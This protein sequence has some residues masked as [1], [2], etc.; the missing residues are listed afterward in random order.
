M[1]TRPSRRNTIPRRHCGCR[2]PSRCLRQPDTPRRIHSRRRPLR[3]RRDR[4]A[5]TARRNPRTTPAKRGNRAV[6]MVTSS[7]LGRSPSHTKTSSARPPTRRAARI[8]VERRLPPDLPVQ[9]VERGDASR[10][11][12]RTSALRPSRPRPGRRPSRGNRR[13]AASTMASEGSTPTSEPVVSRVGDHRGHPAIAAA[14]VQHPLIAPD[15]QVAEGVLG[16]GLLKAVD[17][18][19]RLRIPRQP[20]T[21]HVACRLGAGSRQRVHPRAAGRICWTTVRRKPSLAP[22]ALAQW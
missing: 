19:V 22:A 10:T 3:T 8:R 9:G 20:P 1:S 14:D 11:P 13:R 12:T 6:S 15:N 21:H 18:P 7:M 5:R 4:R 2:S 17:Q 16:D